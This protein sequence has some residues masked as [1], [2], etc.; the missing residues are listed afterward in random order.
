VYLLELLFVTRC[1]MIIL[2][3]D[4]CCSWVFFGSYEEPP[5]GE[6]RA[7]RWHIPDSPKFLGFVEL[8]GGDEL[9]PGDTSQFGLAFLGFRVLWVISKW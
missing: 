5:G 6:T 2:S 3:S 9:P 4:S 8:P 7:A 1:V